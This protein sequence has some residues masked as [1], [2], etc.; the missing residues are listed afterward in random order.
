[1]LHKQILE[2]CRQGYKLQHRTEQSRWYK[3]GRDCA[4]FTRHVV[5]RPPSTSKWTSTI[6]K[7]TRSGATITKE[8]QQRLLE[9]FL[10]QTRTLFRRLGV[11]WWNVLSFFPFPLWFVRK[12]CIYC[13]ISIWYTATM[14]I[15]NNNK[16]TIISI[17]RVPK[18]LKTSNTSYKTLIIRTL[19]Y[20]QPQS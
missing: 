1:M 13:L 2:R 17:D 3:V 5:S 18:S 19:M 15:A 11:Y 6:L 16:K 12:E 9:F 20:K 4:C 7:L 10:D 14:T 8:L